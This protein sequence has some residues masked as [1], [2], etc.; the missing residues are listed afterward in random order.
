MDDDLKAPAEKTVKDMG[1]TMSTV[2]TVF[3]TQAVKQQRFQFPIEAGG[4][5]EK[6]E[7]S[8]L[9]ANEASKAQR[10]FVT[11]HPRLL[12]ELKPMQKPRNGS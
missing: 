12:I 6:R 5:A 3:V 9:S 2:I 1:M 7:A 11:L 10:G 8:A 4:G